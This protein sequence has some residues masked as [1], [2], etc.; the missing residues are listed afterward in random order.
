MSKFTPLKVSIL[1]IIWGFYW[2]FWFERLRSVQEGSSL[3]EWQKCTD[4]LIV[5]WPSVKVKEK[6]KEE[7]QKEKK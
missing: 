3:I 4:K 6:E 2:E 7:K 5:Q 1:Q